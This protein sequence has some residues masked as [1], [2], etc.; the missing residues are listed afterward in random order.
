[1]NALVS[2]LQTLSN[3]LPELA[4]ANIRQIAARGPEHVQIL[5]YD[6]YGTSFIK[7]FGAS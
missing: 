7:R 6:F 1:M 4:P 3:A 2:A 5:T